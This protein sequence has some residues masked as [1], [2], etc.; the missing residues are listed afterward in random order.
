MHDDLLFLSHFDH[1]RSPRGPGTLVCRTNLFREH[2]R[3]RG[4]SA[5]PT[6]ARCYPGLGKRA[7]RLG[8]VPFGSGGVGCASGGA[9]RVAAPGGR[10]MTKFLL[11]SSTPRLLNYA[12]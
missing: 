1:P 9:S 4:I 3:P 8:G 2:P 6:L 5:D 12:L 10:S 11:D 7:R